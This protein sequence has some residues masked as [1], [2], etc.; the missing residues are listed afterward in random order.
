MKKEN[1]DVTVAYSNVAG[2]VD[3]NGVC[4][5]TILKSYLTCIPD[6]E[7]DIGNKSAQQNHNLLVI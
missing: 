2:V 5:L 7:A 3:A 4:K 6:M 1:C